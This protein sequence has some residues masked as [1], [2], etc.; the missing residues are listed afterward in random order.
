MKPVFQKLRLFP[1]WGLFG[2]GLLATA[3]TTYQVKQ[4]IDEDIAER[5]AAVSDVVAIKIQ[6]RLEDNALVL[7]SGSAL[8][9]ASEK[10]TMQEWL[11]FFKELRPRDDLGLV[12]GFAYNEAI[13]APQLKA[14]ISR[15]RREGHVD[16]DIHP[17]GLSDFYTPVT[18]IEPLNDK[19]KKSIGFDVFAD[20]SRR[21]ALELS[22][23]SGNA[24]LSGK[25]T[26]IQNSA[27]ETRAGALMY[28]PIYQKGATL[29]TTAM[30]RSAI[31]GWV[32]S[33]FQIH[34]LV[35]GLFQQWDAIP[36]KSI[37]LRIYDGLLASPTAML[38]EH[39][40]AMSVMT[41]P[42][43]LIFQQRTINFNGHQWSLQFEQSSPLLSFKYLAALAT[44]MGGTL[45]SLLLLVLMRTMIINRSDAKRIADALSETIKQRESVIVESEFRWKFA[46]E[47][48]GQGLWD[49]DILTQNLFASMTMRDMLGMHEHEN[50]TLTEGWDGR[51]HPDDQM[52]NKLVTYEALNGKRHQFTTDYRIRCGDDSYLWVRSRGT[53][54]KLDEKNQPLRLIG[55]ITDIS[56][57]KSREAQSQVLV[58]QAAL[59]SQIRSAILRNA[60]NQT[61]LFDEVCT[62]IV[63]TANLSMAW[64]GQHNPETMTVTPIASF[65]A[66]MWYLD[67]IQMSSDLESKWGTSPCGSAIREGIAQWQHA[68]HQGMQAWRRELEQTA[69]CDI[70]ALPLF[71][72]GQVIGA[73]VL[74]S[75]I[76]DF[77]D[78]AM[79]E[80]LEQVVA[81]INAALDVFSKETKQLL[82]VV[83]LGKS[84][85]NARLATEHARAAVEKLNVYRYALDEFASVVTTDVEG[86]ISYA[87][88]QF[89]DIT[90][91]SE[92]ELLGKNPVILNSGIHPKGF[93]KAM[94]EQIMRGEVWHADVCNR[95]KDGH[96]YWVDT[97]VVAL[98]DSHG[99]P[100]QYLSL[101][102]DISERK[103][104]ELELNHHR[105]NLQ[106]LVDQKT[107]DLQQSILLTKYAKE[108][109]ISANQ[110]KSEFL[111]NMSHEIRT[112]MNGVIGM[113]DILQATDLN[114]EQHRMLDTVHQ[115]SLSLLRILNDILDFSKIEAGKLAI[116]AI[117][118]HLRELAE[119]VVQLM[120]QGA[121]SRMVS[122]ELL[123]D[124]ALPDWILSDPTRLRQILNNLLSNATKFLKQ[125]RGDVALHIHAC[126]LEDG[127]SGIQFCV[128]DNGIGMSDEVMGK[129]FQKF[130][131]ADESTARQFGGTGLGLSIIQ[132]L[133]EMQQGQ[134]RV[135]SELNVGST[136]TVTLPLI[137][138]I[139]PAD[140][141]MRFKPDLT[142]VKVLSVCANPARSRLLQAYL[143]AEGVELTVV[144]DMA[145]ALDFL[146]IH[147]GKFILLLDQN[148][149]ETLDW[150]PTLQIVR[151]VN[152]G[153]GSYEPGCIKIKA[154]PIFLHHLVYG[155]AAASGRLPLTEG[156]DQIALQ[157]AQNGPSLSI[158]EAVASRQ[159]ILLAE[160]NEINR[161]VIQ[162]QLRILGYVAEMAED[163]EIALRM[164]ESGR[165]ALLLTDCNMPRMDGFQ[166]TEA[167]RAAEPPGTKLPIIAVTANAM[168][169]EIQ[170][171][172]ERGMDDYLS[173]PLRLNKLAEMLR[174]WMPVASEIPVTSAALPV[175]DEHTLR[176]LIGDNPP[177]QRRLLQKFLT[178]AELQITS[179][180]AAVSA[181]T[182][183]IVLDEAH[184]LKSS[185]RSVGA[186]ALGDLLQALEEAAHDQDLSACSALASS[187][188]AAFVAVSALIQVHLSDT[189]H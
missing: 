64:I 169:G 117:P 57:E 10:V 146:Q 25:I 154:L 31:I 34:E 122:V 136:F 142:G 177:T 129:L 62:I 114:A 111:A 27:G 182:S 63:N 127:S 33:P 38:Y 19:N 23:D 91:Y 66:D 144:V 181:G 167:I 140:R 113:V 20:P 59:I 161:E 44:M 15:M 145:S 58:R 96:L 97:T 149:I 141:T 87:N 37:D 68:S 17:Q 2:L 98:M 155:I 75:E 118:V 187:V 54:V 148:D 105:Q 124:P 65:G 153:E 164:W 178:N 32:S 4:Y 134:I 18:Y 85:Q 159:L 81:D 130:M 26:L 147:D 112:P 94:Y 30:R 36:G 48:A 61:G 188:E 179:I 99:Q 71:Q 29:T 28:F 74:Y 77:F 184:K 106:E 60:S 160:D 107:A 163:G 50:L 123:V 165:Y 128:T 72:D 162:E 158:D 108:V 170:R 69:W 76:D 151:L 73:L 80:V 131:Q 175:W 22:R 52:A 119:G 171:C 86:N 109:A 5:F 7:R 90:G 135:R 88:K 150:P 137:E 8:F 79:R 156:R 189:P 39:R 41:A 84:E 168:Q 46:I 78:L 166:L 115:S 180:C 186:L 104:N 35:E 82:A 126:I 21:T 51:I 174:M 53:V 157:Q 100:E 70:G 67:D 121:V 55:T 43:D 143:D 14:H 116:E 12:Q 139:A 103:K 110:A 95:A 92:S 120:V 16:Y 49:Y 45:I 47:G 89:V 24:A 173:K 83:A 185:A 1:A 176:S 42:Q 102:I 183:A 152:W 125:N 172:R 13:S 6:H 9:A 138:A 11:N 93:F 132:R 133:V 101:R 40:A 3:L 56:E